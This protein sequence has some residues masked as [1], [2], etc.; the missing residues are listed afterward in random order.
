ME[1]RARVAILGSQESFNPCRI[2]RVEGSR[3]RCPGSLKHNPLTAAAIFHRLHASFSR[4]MDH[5]VAKSN[6]MEPVEVPIIRRRQFI[7]TGGISS[8]HTHAILGSFE[9]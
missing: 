8:K 5:D 4:G 3:T 1:T 7:E 6:P 2:G 9:G